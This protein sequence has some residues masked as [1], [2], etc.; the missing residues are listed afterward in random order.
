LAFVN[1][2]VLLSAWSE[3]RPSAREENDFIRLH[4]FA[5]YG[6]WYLG[7]NDEKPEETKG[8]CEFPLWGFRKCPPVWL[9]RCQY[10]HGNIESATARLHGMLDGP[11]YLVAE[12][13]TSSFQRQSRA[14]SPTP[15]AMTRSPFQRFTTQKTKL[16]I[17]LTSKH[18]I[19]GK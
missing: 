15:D 2:L 9:T 1:N 14:R 10:Q 6:K 18:V 8:H 16:S 11:S 19:N 3:H 5:E 17:M 7:I 4:G 13:L 12:A